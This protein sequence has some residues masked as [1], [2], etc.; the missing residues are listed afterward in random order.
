MQGYIWP[1]I[2]YNI[3]NILVALMNN[4]YTVMSHAYILTSSRKLL[5]RTSIEIS[6]TNHSKLPSQFRFCHR[7]HFGHRAIGMHGMQHGAIKF[8]RGDF[9]IFDV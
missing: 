7:I 1:K 9:L 5:L 2:I 8:C 6:L 4:L 3:Y